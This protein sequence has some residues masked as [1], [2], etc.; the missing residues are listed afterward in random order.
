MRKSAM[1]VVVRYLLTCKSDFNWVFSLWSCWIV[2]FASTTFWVWV[3]SSLEITFLSDS[4]LSTIWSNLV[5][6]MQIYCSPSEVFLPGKCCSFAVVYG[7]Q[8]NVHT[9]PEFEAGL[10]SFVCTS[11]LISSDKHKLLIHQP[12]NQPTHTVTLDRAQYQCKWM[13]LTHITQLI[14]PTCFNAI[15]HANLWARS[16]QNFSLIVFACSE[17]MSKQ[18]E[19]RYYLPFFSLT[20]DTACGCGGLGTRTRWQRT[21]GWNWAARCWF[22]QI[23][24]RMLICT[25][26]CKHVELYKV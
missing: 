2:S 3:A 5:K 1:K 7:H 13:Q 8:P 20:G 26:L 22:V 24:I 12:N 11:K 17:E 15:E 23:T 16:K 14:H 6:S 10:H 19:C 9:W 4:N 18:L 21:C 25:N